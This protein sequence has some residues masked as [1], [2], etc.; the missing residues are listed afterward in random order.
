M[1]RWWWGILVVGAWEENRAVEEEA[2]RPTRAACEFRTKKRE[3]A[4][5]ASSRRA[6]GE[7]PVGGII[8][9]Q[10]DG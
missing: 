1:E 8:G 9:S 10:V 6:A 2:S 5:P 3:P 4:K 7:P